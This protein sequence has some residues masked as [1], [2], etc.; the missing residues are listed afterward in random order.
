M[1]EAKNSP[2]TFTVSGTK[3]E[4]DSNISELK[5]IIDR[6]DRRIYALEVHLEHTGSKEEIAN[7][8]ADLSKAFNT[9]IWQIVGI[10]LAVLAVVI[11]I[12]AWLTPREGATNTEPQVIVIQAQPTS[13][14]SEEI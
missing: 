13:L 1:N 7:L 3:F 9:H 11:S 5:T 2:A 10:M 14:K 8:R 4:K 12:F 6:Q